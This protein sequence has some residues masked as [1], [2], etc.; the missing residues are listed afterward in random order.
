MPRMEPL[1]AFDRAAAAAT[2]IVAGIT[3][4]QLALPSPCTE[5]TVRE[6]VNHLVT[7]NLM[8]VAIVEGRAHPDRNVDRLG[9]DPKAVFAE[10]LAASRAALHQPGLL[11]R[12]VTTPM[13]EAPGAVLV[14]MRVAELLVHGWDLA[15]ATGRS[16]D[17]DA[18]LA[19]SVLAAWQARLADRPRTLTPFADPQ[20][21]PDDATAADRLAAY[22]GRSVVGM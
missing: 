21:V 12:T 11:E 22:L 2:A 8:S 5:W 14:Q 4:D 10:S 16:T 6:L 13:G 1:D 17:I 15:R 7:G 9:S 20:P 19:G 18:E 3:D